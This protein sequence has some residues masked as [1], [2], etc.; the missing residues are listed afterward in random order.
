MIIQKY[1]ESHQAPA[2][3]MLASA[4]P[5]GLIP[6]TVRMFL[7]HPLVV[8]KAVLTLSMFPV[9]STPQL[10]QEAFFS[11]DM[12]GERLKSYL[13]QQ[14]DESFRAYLD[15]LGLSLPRPRRI[16]G[17]FL[18]LGVENDKMISPKEVIA[19]GRTYGVEAEFFPGMAHDMMLE[20][21]WQDVA[22]RILSWLNELG[23]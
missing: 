2:A 10:A 1:L 11:E 23:L 6:A 18:I 20:A 13:A 19:T 16:K 14:Q 4:P 7:R 9:I 22:D 12:P 5:T 17:K 8:S 3:I 21:G 15:M